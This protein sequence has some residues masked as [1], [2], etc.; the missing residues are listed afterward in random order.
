[1]TNVQ[2]PM[3]LNPDPRPGRW[4]LPLV[5]LGMMAFT[6]VFVQNLPA[7]EGGTQD[8][9]ADGTGDTTATT[10]TTTQDGGS[11]TTTAP[12]PMPVSP[13]IQAYLDQVAAAETTLLE[14]QAEMANINSAWDADPAEIEYAVA[15]DRL[16]DLA[17]RLE[18]WASDLSAVVPPPALSEIHGTIVA[19]A[20]A[21]A[22]AADDV[23]VGFEGPDAAPRIEAL[24]V[25]DTAVRQFTAVA[26][27]I[28][29]QATTTGA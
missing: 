27:D 2:S 15:R 16:A 9:S 28:E 14:F 8:I 26:D 4:L 20:N 17:N 19:T 6:Y 24:E 21:A 12:A 3:V 11:T 7:T 25:F 29:L 1:M 13:E 18:T 10:T 5:I 23:L 22:N